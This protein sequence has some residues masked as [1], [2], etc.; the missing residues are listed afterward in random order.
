MWIL[1]T[2]NYF[3]YASGNDCLG[4]WTSFTLRVA[5]LKCAIQSCASRFRSSLRYRHY[6]SVIRSTPVMPTFTYD[7]SSG[8][9]D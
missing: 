3:G 6:F 4:T 5:R 7:S 8:I 2:N 1:L 9:N